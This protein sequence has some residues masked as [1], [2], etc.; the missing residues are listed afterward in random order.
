MFTP[1]SIGGSIPLRNRIVMQSITR[2]RCVEDNMP[3][4]AVIQHYVERARD[5][6]GLIVTEGTFIWLNGA[7]WLHTPVM[8]NES[9]AKSWRKVT[10]AVHKEGAKIFF[11][12]WHPGRQQNENMPMLKESGYPVL[13][14]SKIP[15]T[16]GK[17]H[18]PPG[19]ADHTV[20]IT[21][22]IDPQEIIEQFR[23]SV[24]LA[25]QAGFDGIEILAQGGYLLQNFLHSCS[26][27]RTDN[28]GG[29]A[30]NR[31]R[32]LLQVVDAILSIWPPHTIGVKICPTDNIADMSIPYAEI[33][34]TYNYLIPQL[35][36]R[37]LGFINL[38]R[39]GADV[40]PANGA[41]FQM[42]ESRPAG[43]EL[44]V[45]YDP[46]V[47]FGPLVK[48]EGSKTALVVNHEV[49]VQEGERLIREGKVD[50]V[51]FG[52]P[53]IH[54]PDLVSRVKRGI[55]LALNDRGGKVY[56]G[57]GLKPE[58][59]YNDWPVAVQA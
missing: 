3:G 10:D 5:G 24:E 34:S 54:N 44:P 31:S 30:E 43:T 58:E 48:F 56:Y 9:H 55:P 28:Y 36:S 17:Y 8:F 52:R 22:I 14:P 41:D 13:A 18:D 33:S 40:P 20:N 7:Q 39:R 15:A 32:F 57:D 6:V 49:T 51:G 19:I 2:N 1:Y 12:A 27:T 35:V 42:A 23:N 46:L 53:F 38:S 45:G 47:E 50:L 25:K 29:S 11:Q 16:G 59:G 26:N 37:G 21:E 4:E